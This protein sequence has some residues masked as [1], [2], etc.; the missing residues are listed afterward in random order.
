MVL[1]VRQNDMHMQNEMKLQHIERQ[2]IGAAQRKGSDRAAVTGWE[3]CISPPG[4]AAAVK[5]LDPV[6]R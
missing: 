5:T 6:K 3:M 1:Y 2:V 4:E